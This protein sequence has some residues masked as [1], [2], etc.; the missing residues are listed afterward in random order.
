[1]STRRKFLQIIPFGPA[2]LTAC[3]GGGSEGATQSESPA[4]GFGT[5]APTPAPAPVPAPTP[6]PAPVP[7]K[8][9]A[10]APTPAPA[11]APAPGTGAAPSPAPSTPPAPAPAPAPGPAP[12]PSPPPQ[13]TQLPGGVYIRSRRLNPTALI[14]IDG[15]RGTQ[16]SRYERFQV[17]VIWSAAKAP[18]QKVTLVGYDL[19][20]GGS[21]TALTA[22]TYTLLIDDQPFA[23]VPRSGDTAVFDVPLAGLSEG[24]HWLDVTSDPM[25]TA[26]PLPFYVLKGA[27]AAP[28]ALM[29]IHVH[30][31][32]LN[33]PNPGRW[34]IWAVTT[35]DRWLQHYGMVPAR[36][37]PTEQPLTRRE[38]PPL[39][40]IN[41]STA[42][43]ST[44]IVPCREM[45]IH[46]ATVTAEGVWTTSGSETYHYSDFVAK[47]PVWA[48]LDGPR[49][50]GT[51]A[52]ATHLQIGREDKVYGTDPWR[53]FRIDADGR[54]TTLVGWR[55][56]TPPNNWQS[57]ANLEL[58]GDWSAI[59]PGRRGLHEVWGFAW[60]ARTLTVN[61]AAPP[62]PSQGNEKPHEVGPVAFIAD[63]QNNRVLKVQFSATDRSMPAKVTEFA[64]GLADPWDIVC[65]DGVLYVSERA[66]H[67]ISRFDAANGSRLSPLISGA[68]LAYVDNQRFTRRRANVTL[69]QV[70]AEPCV[71]PEGLY[72]MDN[73]LYFG[74]ATQQQVRR[75]D[76]ATGQLDARRWPMLIDGNTRFCKIAVSDGTFMPKGTVFTSTWSN[77][78]YG[79]PITLKAEP[80]ATWEQSVQFFLP[81][82]P[83]G[84]V[85]GEGGYATCVA[86]GHGRLIAGAVQEG[87]YMVSAA[88]PAEQPVSEAAKRGALDYWR[89]GY[90]TLYG[91]NG[92][93]H[94]GLP[95]PW[96]QTADIDAYLRYCG[97]QA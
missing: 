42:M 6:A 96:G 65:K 84:T 76:L 67:R 57:P 63:T 10:P 19:A 20:S 45:D 17:P 32:Q 48:L 13:P 97:H 28:H 31:A 78:R 8:P 51:V 46:R 5:P 25:R 7:T 95:L 29:P 35:E 55:H 38:Y 15:G 60:D 79:W 66:A 89:R 77:N 18:T 69:A 91:V 56:Q 61:E 82:V 53:L 12:A 59:P 49:G 92:W 37:Q 87:I 70:Q 71:L 52:A 2:A 27:T 34:D 36:F 21:K 83:R 41:T 81:G 11:P 33:Y 47:T 58:V 16:T 62:I 1:M 4:A 23:T 94:Y 3:G 80:E 85:M 22:A 26:Q 93:G 88:T 40:V 64:T 43:A 39:P 30:S 14:L 44:Q 68:D 24:W 9:P 74:S 90:R 54:I 75:V 73:F 86:V 50:R 72:L